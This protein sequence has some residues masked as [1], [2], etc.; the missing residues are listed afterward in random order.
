[1]NRV[2]RAGWWAG[3]LVAGVLGC[4]GDTGPKVY[5]VKG[6]VT[7]NGQPLTDVIVN[8]SPIDGDP[9]K[10]ASGQVDASGNYSLR[11]GPQG[12]EGAP[13]GRYKVYLTPVAPTPQEGQ[14]YGGS[15]PQTPGESAGP[16]Q[17]TTNIPQQWLS[18]ASTPF[19]AEVKAEP[20]TIPIDVK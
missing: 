5:P 3:L 2:V 19:E 4:R 20:N 13:P 9:A 12:K 17:A 1:M 8:F 14:S 16:P 6:Q 7:L 15:G 18:A 11:S 10:M